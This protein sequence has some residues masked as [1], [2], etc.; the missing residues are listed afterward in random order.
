[1][2]EHV[3]EY[4]E[5]EY[6]DENDNEKDVSE[7]S[8]FDKGLQEI[9]PYRRSYSVLS[10]DALIDLIKKAKDNKWNALDLSTCG[11]TELPAEIGMLT[12]LEILDLGNDRPFRDK[13]NKPESNVFITLPKEIGKL[14][15]LKAINLYGTN[16][17]YLPKEF[18]DLKNLTYINLNEC[19]FK[20]FPLEICKLKN[21]CQLAINKSFISLPEQIGDLDNLQ[22]L[23]LPESF[24]TTLPESIGNLI[25]LEVLYLGRSQIVLLPNKIKNLKNLIKLDFEDSEIT[26]FI[27]P[28]IFSQSPHEIIEY[29]LRYQ[30]DKDKVILN[31]SKMIIVGQGGVGKTCILNRIIH[32]IFVD[33]VSTEGIDISYWNFKS[34]GKKYRLN[35]WD[36]GG[37]EIYHATHQFFLTERSLYLYVWDARQEDEYGRID[38]WLNTIQS[39]ADDSPIIVVV[40]K[41]DKLRKNIKYIDIDE[42][43][44]RFPQIV[45]CYNVSC[46]DNINIDKLKEEIIVQAKELPLMESTWFSTW[47]K[48]RQRLELLSKIKNIIDYS[49]YLRICLSYSIDAQEALSLIKYLHDLGVV[50][51]FYQDILLRNI[52]ILN[53]EW[54]TDAVYKV[55]DAQ[56]NVLKG[57]NGILYVDDLNKI[58]T[59]DEMYPKETYPYILKLMENFQ[60]S[61]VIEPNCTFLIA[62][63]LDNSE[64]NMPLEFTGKGNLNFR[65]KYNFLPAGIM[66]RFIVKT[67]MYLIDM[68]GVKMCWRKGAY[69]QYNNAHGLVRLHDSITDRYVD[70]KVSGGTARNRRELLAIIMS[71]FEQIHQSIPKIDYTKKVLCNCSADCTYLHDYDYLNKLE[72]EGIYEER[73]KSS[74]QMVDINMLLDGIQI[75]RE[76][77]NKMTEINYA[78]VAPV[79]TV[80]NQVNT[81]NEIN[82]KISNE[83]KQSINELQGCMN[84]LKDEIVDPAIAESVEKINSCIQKLEA[85]QTKD[86][87]IKSGC[88][89][90]I[91]RFLEDCGDAETSIGKTI[92]GIKHG[93]SILQDVAEKYNNIA[94]WCGMPVVPKAFLK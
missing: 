83:I 23:Y 40:N 58:W 54:G 82:I 70:I 10:E 50:L 44:I 75:N 7:L 88:L 67:H 61:F 92:K 71:N 64:R 24:I 57:R 37:Q 6:I 69:L 29:I 63:L 56:A 8:V 3:K 2:L 94:Q 80:T 51:Y 35:V 22:Q 86:D 30:K 85:S 73:C 72:C 47:I 89:N 1:M 43:K 49:T 26:Q 9:L 12:D 18:S 41:C 45:A 11:L 66:T 78:P 15:N 34:N 46:Q 79:I 31:E 21:L 32:D 52:I 25:N 62:E 84:N 59:N 87:V 16:I 38:Y 19:D 39:F 77:T 81:S 4:D 42:L 33:G 65:Y 68:D 5:D 36:F 27:P 90:K 14:Q 48:V 13:S 91:R 28:E 20:E 60:L 74:L 76:R 55:L 17:K 93:Y 53:P